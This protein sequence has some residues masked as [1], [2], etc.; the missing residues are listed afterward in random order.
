VFSYNSAEDEASEVDQELQT[1]QKKC[2]KKRTRKL[3][4]LKLPKVLMCPTSMY[5]HTGTYR[6]VSTTAAASATNMHSQILT[7][8]HESIAIDIVYSYVGLVE[9]SLTVQ[10][11][12]KMLHGL[13]NISKQISIITRISRRAGRLL[14]CYADEDRSHYRLLLTIQSGPFKMT[15]DSLFFVICTKLATT[16]RLFSALCGINTVGIEADTAT[17]FP[18]HQ[19]ERSCIRNVPGYDPTLVVTKQVSHRSIRSFHPATHVLI[20]SIGCPRADIRSYILACANCETVTAIF[21]SIP[22]SD[23]HEKEVLLETCGLLR[24]PKRIRTLTRSDPEL[25]VHLKMLVS[26][27]KELDHHWVYGIEITEIVRARI[28]NALRKHIQTSISDA[29]NLDDVAYDNLS[30]MRDSSEELPTSAS[31]LPIPVPS[32]TRPE[33]RP[34]NGRQS[35]KQTN[36]ATAWCQWKMARTHSLENSLVTVP[37]GE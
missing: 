8:L 21:I 34:V 23:L 11:V 35:E 25:F 10:H 30:Q 37:D 17:T 3:K 1:T 27:A 6:D 26:G 9:W 2:R 36:R 19:A 24:K 13:R 14:N 28:R 20:E 12:C 32:K 7:C 16:Q 18:R 15:Q 22:E 5:L 33:I 4:T 31:Q 29:T